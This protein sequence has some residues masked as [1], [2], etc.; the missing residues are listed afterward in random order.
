V[1]FFSGK[2]QAKLWALSIT[3]IIVAIN[4]I[5]KFFITYLVLW[6][7]FE[8][9][10]MQVGVIAQALFVAQFFN[11]GIIILLVNANFSEHLP[12]EVASIF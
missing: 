8:T 10:T 5:L 1:N 4:T 3:V 6:I 11:T 12:E 7:G 9:V 2:L